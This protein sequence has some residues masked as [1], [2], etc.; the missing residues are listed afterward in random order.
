[1]A[2]PRRRRD[3]AEVVERLTTPLEERVA[4]AVAFELALGVEREGALVAK[5]VDLHRVVDHQIDVDQRVDLLRI[6]TDL[7]HRVAHRRQV[8]H[9]RH[10]GE[11]L[12]QHPRRLVGDLGAG[13]GRR[14]PA[15]DRLDVGGGRRAAVL[16]PQHVLQQHL[17]RVGQPRHVE[18]LLQ[19]VEPEDLVG[20]P[21]NL[22]GRTRAEG[23]ETAH[24]SILGN[25]GRPPDLSACRTDPS[26][27]WRRLSGPARRWRSSRRCP[28]PPG[29]SGRGRAAAAGRP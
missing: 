17:D 10:A 20:A 4:L 27:P 18:A 2:D 1:M 6:A 11:V 21:R 26:R 13:L 3:D 29:R 8:D 12:H 19:R 16:Q 28:A 9:R 14:V 22:E 23:V 5:G 7:R 25:G 15:R 24:N